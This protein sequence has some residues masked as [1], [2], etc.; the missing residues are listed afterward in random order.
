MELG[1]ILDVHEDITQLQ[2]DGVSLNSNFY[3]RRKDSDV[4]RT[5]NAPPYR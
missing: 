4:G 5:T 1:D 3:K 2:K